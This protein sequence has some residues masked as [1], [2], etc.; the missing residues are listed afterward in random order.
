M[1]SG[2]R[3]ATTIIAAAIVMMATFGAAPVPGATINGPLTDTPPAAK[4]L[5][6]S[7]YDGS[8]ITSA[9]N[10]SRRMTYLKAKRPD[11]RHW[12][13]S[14]YTYNQCPVR[15]YWLVEVATNGV[16]AAAEGGARRDR[17]GFGATASR[18]G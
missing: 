3:K 1:R 6:W 18:C 5:V 7:P 16:R 15:Y 17:D 10:C 2:I 12:R 11:I 9:A 14:R 4:V 13:C 8:R